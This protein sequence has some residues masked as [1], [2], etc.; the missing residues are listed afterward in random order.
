MLKVSRSIDSF[1]FEGNHLVAI[2]DGSL[3][4]T[5]A[6]SIRAILKK[7]ACDR[8]HLKLLHDKIPIEAPQELID[9]L[10]DDLRKYQLVQSLSKADQTNWVEYIYGTSSHDAKAELILKLLSELKTH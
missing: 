1:A 6:K 7:E 4:I 5:V 10:K 2:E 9:C 8:V 3:F